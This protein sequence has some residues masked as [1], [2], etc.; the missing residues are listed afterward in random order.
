MIDPT[1]EQELHRQLALLPMEKQRHVLDF[2][3]ILSNAPPQGVRGS[4]LL[5]FAGTIPAGDLAKM[6]A[7][8]EADC[9]NVDIDGW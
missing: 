3:R 1:I 4:S 6:K 5:S 8:I 9:E 2:A 7:A